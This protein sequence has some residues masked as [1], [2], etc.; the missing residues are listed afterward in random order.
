[1]SDATISTDLAAAL[2]PIRAA[3]RQQERPSYPVTHDRGLPPAAGQAGSSASVIGRATTT[4]ASRVFVPACARGARVTLAAVHR[5]RAR[6]SRSA[7]RARRVAEAARIGGRAETLVPRG[8][9][10]RAGRTAAPRSR[11]ARGN[12]PKTE[13]NKPPP[14]HAPAPSRDSR[15]QREAAPAAAPHG[16]AT[17]V[18]LLH[19]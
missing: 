2:A 13:I 9:N 17:G 11:R 16:P 19:L 10:L 1:M 5:Q 14:W 6:R 8:R 15:A 3:P 7:R 12:T 18:D 4:E